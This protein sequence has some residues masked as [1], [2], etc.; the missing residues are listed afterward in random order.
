MGSGIVY[1]VGSG[2]GDK[3]LITVKGAKILSQCDVVVYDYL[4][5]KEVLE[6]CKDECHKICAEEFS[7]N[8]TVDRVGKM[9][10]FIIEK[11]REGKRVVRLKGGDPSIFA[12]LEE[13]EKILKENNI[14][15]GLFRE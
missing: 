7:Q 1:I 2:P 6:Y 5:G 15:Y 12:R 9:Y 3:G 14:E 8:H 11:V 10:E 13:E 4:C